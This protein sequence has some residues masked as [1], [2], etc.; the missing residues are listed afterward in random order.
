M[1]N[2]REHNSARDKA[3]RKR[4]PMQSGQKTAIPV[5]IIEEDGYKYR[6]FA[7]YGK[8]RIGQA[9]QAGWEHVTDPKT[10]EHVKQNAGGGEHLWLMR[11]P[12]EFWEEDRKIKRDKIIEINRETQREANKLVGGAVPE[13]LPNQQASVIERDNI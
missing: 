2:K 3:T 5:D 6:Q 4:I 13:Y 7:D 12:A 1:G 10:N 9:L 8:G 11:I